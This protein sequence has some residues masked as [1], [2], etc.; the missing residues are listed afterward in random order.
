MKTNPHFEFSFRDYLQKRGSLRICE[1]DKDDVPSHP[2]TGQVCLCR[3]YHQDRFMKPR[4][5]DQ[6]TLCKK[7]SCGVLGTFRKQP[8]VPVF[9]MSKHTTRWFSTARQ[10]S[11]KPR[12]C[13]HFHLQFSINVKHTTRSNTTLDSIEFHRLMTVLHSNMHNVLTTPKP[14]TLD[15]QWKTHQTT[16]LV[17]QRSVATKRPT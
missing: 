12:S 4:L 13:R 10:T 17:Q 15:T 5:N 2:N 6:Q 11:Q 16:R 9:F 14:T 1:I 8:P 7:G 3:Q